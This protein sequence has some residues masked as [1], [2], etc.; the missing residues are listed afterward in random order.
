MPDMGRRYLHV[1]AGVD[2]GL[3][4]IKQPT[5]P[6]LLRFPISSGPGFDPDY[7]RDSSKSASGYPVGR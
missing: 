1:S 3:I 4:W 2:R 5:I 6:Q 7:F